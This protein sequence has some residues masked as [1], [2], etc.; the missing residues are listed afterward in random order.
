MAPILRG[1]VGTTLAEVTTTP[2]G[3]NE[4]QKIKAA[5][6][7]ST[8]IWITCSGTV[9]INISADGTVAGATAAFWSNVDDMFRLAQKNKIYIKATLISFDH[10]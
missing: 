5:G 1:T 2:G 8:R 10:F 9:G 6:G 4:F 7:N 3:D